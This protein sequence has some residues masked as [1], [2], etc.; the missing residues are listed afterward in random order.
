MSS[1]SGRTGEFSGLFNKDI[2]LTFLR[3][4]PSL[5]YIITLPKAPSPNTITL[6]IG[7]TTYESGAGG[8]DT[9][10]DYRSCQVDDNGEEFANLTPVSVDFSVKSTTDSR[11]EPQDNF[12]S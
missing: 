12:P 7:I 6:G 9:N 11:S 1:H 4:L 10:S 2:N 8:G 3:A 5:L